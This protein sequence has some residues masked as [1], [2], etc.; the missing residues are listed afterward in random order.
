MSI[1][2]RKFAPKKRVVLRRLWKVRAYLPL[3]P[4]FPACS[5]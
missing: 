5:E 3:E 2:I 1:V 4:G